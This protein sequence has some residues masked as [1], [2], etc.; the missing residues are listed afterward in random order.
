MSKY[1]RARKKIPSKNNYI[2]IG[3]YKRVENIKW[4]PDN[5]KCFF[6]LCWSLALLLMMLMTG[7]RIPIYRRRQEYRKRTVEH[8]DCDCY[9]NLVRETYIRRNYN[10]WPQVERVLTAKM[11]KFSLLGDLN[12]ESHVTRRA[13]AYKI[14]LADADS[15]PSFI[16]ALV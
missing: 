3:H 1:G 13:W 10:C 6:N 15:L 8:F 2:S 16:L 12:H 14:P 9:S 5:K 4:D 7:I 11:T